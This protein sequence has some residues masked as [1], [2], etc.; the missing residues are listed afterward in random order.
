MSIR[1]KFVGL[2]VHQDTIAIAVADEQREAEVRFVGTIENNVEILKKSLDR[3]SAGDFELHVCYEAGPCGYGIYRFL[4]K[5]GIDCII[6][7]PSSMP[8][9][10]GDRV[11]TD[12]RDAQTLA[13]LLRA[14]ELS[15][16]WVPDETHEAIRDVVRARRQVKQEISSAKSSLKSFLLRHERRFSGNAIWGKRYW[17]WLSEQSF[18]FAHQQFVYEEYKQRIVELEA[19]CVRLDEALREAT[20]DWLFSDLVASLQ[21]LRGIKFITAVTLVAEIGDIRRFDNPRQLMAWLGLVPAEYSSGNRIK[22]GEITRTGNSAAR[23][24]LIE[25]AWHYRFPA[26]EG[27]ALQQRNRDIPPHIKAIAWKAQVRLCGKYRR[28]VCKGKKSVKVVTAVARELVGF[29]WD[30]AM[31]I[32]LP[33]HAR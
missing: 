27:R 28:L 25:S 9:R 2:D 20:Q 10:P 6:I 33:R 4:Q 8:R 3:L 23:T 30:I 1:Q 7:S 32:S 14:G 17:R 19:R 13:R 15:S 22:R 29:I 31:H 26:R 16:V 11:K 21:S 24:L 5:H 12:K 18:P